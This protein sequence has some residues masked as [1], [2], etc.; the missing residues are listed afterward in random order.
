[1]TMPKFLLVNP[2]R[3]PAGSRFLHRPVDGPKEAQVVNFKDIAHTLEGIEWDF[4]PGPV[5]THGDWSAANREE[6]AYVAV[7]RLKIVRAAC[8][9]GK[10]DAIVLLGGAEPGFQDAREIGRSFGVV[11]TGC[12]FA[13]MHVAAML[14]DRFSVIDL[15]EAHAKYFSGIVT[16]HRFNERCASIRNLEFPLPRPGV[17]EPH[18]IVEQR[19]RAFAG[20]PSEIVETCVRE[21]VAAIEDDGAEV[22]IFGCS[23]TYWLKPFLEQRLEALGWDV[24]VLEGQGAAIELAKLLVG[25]G[26]NHSGL[27]FPSSTPRVTRRRIVP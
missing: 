7:D 16:Q 23:A 6:F 15:Y 26:V 1:M 8:E 14:G 18:P 5:A 17:S 27:S 11:V 3:L 20:E 2:F 10:Y 24:P 22:L 19:R 25:L 21:A 13:Q 4:D 12:A 9:S